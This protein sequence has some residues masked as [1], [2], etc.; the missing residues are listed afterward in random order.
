MTDFLNHRTFDDL[1]E[2]QTDWIKSEINNARVSWF[3]YGFTAAWC[4]ASL[5]QVLKS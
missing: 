1:D 3:L 4:L 5:V 2:I